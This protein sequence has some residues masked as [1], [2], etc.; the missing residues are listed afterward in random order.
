MEVVSLNGV[1]SLRGRPQD[2]EKEQWIELTAKE[3]ITI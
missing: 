3:G 1:W 2:E